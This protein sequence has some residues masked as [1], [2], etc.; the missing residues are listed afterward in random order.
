[1][2]RGRMQ[3][4]SPSPTIWQSKCR[5][6]S[7]LLDASRTTAKASS[8]NES[9]SAE[10]EARRLRNMSVGESYG[11]C[12]VVWGVSRARGEVSAERNTCARGRSGSI[13]GGCGN[14][15]KVRH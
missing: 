9:S 14:V 12:E 2:P 3:I 8:S 4:P 1:M 10:P 6:P 13:S 5:I 11:R 7:T 15:W